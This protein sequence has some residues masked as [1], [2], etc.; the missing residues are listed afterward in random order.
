LKQQGR[1]LY[2]S[3]DNRYCAA[4]GR[5]GIADHVEGAHDPLDAVGR[6]RDQIDAVA[7]GN[8]SPE[9]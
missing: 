8:P 9:I 4:T 2:P 6:F 7:V 1:A 5:E 3:V